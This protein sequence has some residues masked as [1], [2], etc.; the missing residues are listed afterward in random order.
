MT[1]TQVHLMLNHFSVIGSIFGVVLVVVAM[2]RNSRELVTLALATLLGVAMLSIPVYVTGEPAQEAIARQLGV[3][4]E[5]VEQHAQAAEFAFFAIEWVG[6]LALAGL[7]LFRTEPPPRWFL[8]LLLAGALVT[9]GVMVY[10]GNEG[11]QI[12]HPDLS[13]LT[14]RYRAV[15]EEKQAVRCLTGGRPDFSRVA[16]PM[17][18][19]AVSDVFHI[20]WGPGQ[21]RIRWS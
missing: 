15:R 13:T 9:A 8:G 14:L 20:K 11:R 3:P 4:A 19:T 6:A 17:E 2:V 18:Y 5:V 16:P 10:T 7:W 1:P 21:E 12:R